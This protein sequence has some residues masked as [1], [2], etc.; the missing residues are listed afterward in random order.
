MENEMTKQRRRI[1]RIGIEWSVPFTL[2]LHLWRWT[3][4]LVR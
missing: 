4:R 1:Y 3:W 2:T